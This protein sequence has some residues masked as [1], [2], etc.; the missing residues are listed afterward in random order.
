MARHIYPADAFQRSSV[1]TDTD[2]T[3]V[4]LRGFDHL[5]NALFV[6]NVTWIDAQT[7]SARLGGLNT[8]LIVEM[9]VCNDWHRYL[10]DDQL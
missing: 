5:F 10:G 6:T 8:A 4:I 9:D 7:G 1:H 2:G 3:I